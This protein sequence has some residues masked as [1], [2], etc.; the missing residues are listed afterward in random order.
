MVVSLAYGYY[1][2][3]RVSLKE[4]LAGRNSELQFAGNGKNRDNRRVHPAFGE[5]ADNSGT[6]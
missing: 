1:S 2:H 6:K 3:E 5:F 4:F